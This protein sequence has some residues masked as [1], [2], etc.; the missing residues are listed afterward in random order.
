MEEGKKG[1]GAR[2]S[3]NG[4][5]PPDDERRGR[6]AWTLYCGVYITYVEGRREEEGLDEGSG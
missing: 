3:R 6:Q 1:G 4:G 2:R 5:M